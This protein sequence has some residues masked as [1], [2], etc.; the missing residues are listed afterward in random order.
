MS[1]IQDIVCEIAA[2]EG[3]AIDGLETPLYEVIDPDAL[4]ALITG[5]QS[6]PDSAHPEIDFEYLGYTVTIDR[7]G[8]VSID[9]H[10]STPAE[11]PRGTVAQSLDTDPAELDHR[12][13]ALKD[14]TATIAARER[15]FGDR[16]AGL[17]KVVRKALEVESATLSYVDNDS[18]VFEA[19]DAPPTVDRQAGEIVPLAKTVC[20]RA[21]ET[22]QALVLG[23]V[24]R[25]APEL[26][27]LADG[28]STYLG[29]PV[30]VDH[31]VYGTF[32]FYDS[33]SRDD[34][35]SDW[36]LTLVELLSNWVS[37]ELEQR[38]RE[39][40]MQAATLERPSEAI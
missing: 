11:S 35:F 29:V 14:A 25:E 37:S 33:A 39:R 12:E 10:T 17:L 13:R 3:V 5:A 26:A 30:F 34:G 38:Q 28:I 16:L 24:A 20:K 2:R 19:V 7:R 6:R 21:V 31:E 15:P 36:E 23:D 32:C 8:D 27:N 40:A 1:S 18:Y 4:E 22:E 9:E